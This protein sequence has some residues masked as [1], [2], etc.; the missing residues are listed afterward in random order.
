MKNPLAKQQADATIVLRGP[1]R[2]THRPKSAADAPRKKNAMLNIQIVAESDQSPGA[3]LSTPMTRVSGMLNTESA[4][5][6]RHRKTDARRALPAE[7]AIGC[8]PL[9]RSSCCD[10]ETPRACF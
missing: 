9:W 1:T 4:Y 5:A 10:P 7:R 8:N 6:W 2:S 3:L